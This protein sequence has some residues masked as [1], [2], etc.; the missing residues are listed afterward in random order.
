MTSSFPASNAQAAHRHPAPMANVSFWSCGP[1]REAVNRR[2]PL[3]SHG[4]NL[5]PAHHHAPFLH[6]SP[7]V[8]VELDFGYHIPAH[9]VLL[10]RKYAVSFI[11]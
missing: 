2:L 6:P 11:L 8:V 5:P 10:D 9:R 3:K 7:A 4:M 1:L